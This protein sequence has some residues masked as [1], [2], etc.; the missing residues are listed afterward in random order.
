LD[1]YNVRETNINRYLLNTFKRNV[2]SVNDKEF[3]VIGAVGMASFSA[4]SNIGAAVST[5]ASGGMLAFAQWTSIGL[6]I[7]FSTAAINIIVSY[8]VYCSNAYHT[9]MKILYM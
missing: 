4:I 1:T 3:A 9:Y 6:A 7:G 2:D 8:N 5:H